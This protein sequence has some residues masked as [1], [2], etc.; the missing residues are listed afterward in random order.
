MPS[1][2]TSPTFRDE[3]VKL[4]PAMRAFARSLTNN[5]A[6]T[7]DLVQ[8]AI[9][10]AWSHAGQFTPGTNL[11]AW[12]FTILRNRYYSV[13][14]HQQREVGDPDGIHTARLTISPAQEWGIAGRELKAALMKLP[15]EQRE[16]LVLVG[17]AGASY[18]EA[19]EICGCALGTI[20]SR[21]NRGRARLAD[22]MGMDPG[23]TGLGAPTGMATS[24]AW[25]ARRPA[26][27]H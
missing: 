22:I 24:S 15:V 4:I 9:V 5:A 23:D 16:A 3:L 21:V 8:D 25:D 2:E 12:L 19:A 18:E 20:K 7:D 17:G 27:S 13:A 14:K 1:A 26:S 11:R 10:R 6:D